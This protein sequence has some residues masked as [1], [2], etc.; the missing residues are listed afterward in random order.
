MSGDPALKGSAWTCLGIPS[1][2]QS[3]RSPCFEHTLHLRAA[4]KGKTKIIGRFAWTT[5]EM[6]AR[7]RGTGD[8]FPREE[9][10]G[11][12]AA[13]RLLQ[14]G[15]WTGKGAGSGNGE[16]TGVGVEGGGLGAVAKQREVS[17]MGGAVR[18]GE[19][20]QQRGGEMDGLVPVSPPNTFVRPVGLSHLQAHVVG[21]AGEEVMLHV[22]ADERVA[23]GPVEQGVAGQVEDTQAHEVDPLGFPIGRKHGEADVLREREVGTPRHLQTAPP[24]PFPAEQTMALA[25]QGH[26]GARQPEP[27]FGVWLSTPELALSLMSLHPVLVCPQSH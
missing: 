3:A 23:E 2:R 5:A 22:A 13:G 12:Q 19:G 10:G 9:S 24:S 16:E 20:L 7:L 8:A 4:S 15:I 11:S 25:M 18:R 26:K 27:H 17:G 21:E 6:N 1:S 14:A